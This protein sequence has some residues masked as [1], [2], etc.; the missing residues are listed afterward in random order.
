[1]V[2]LGIW[3]SELRVIHIYAHVVVKVALG[4]GRPLQSVG[5]GGHHSYGHSSYLAGWLRLF[6]SG[7]SKLS[8]VADVLDDVW[9]IIPTPS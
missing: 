2:T 5:H 8:V 6:S 1:M 4:I 9:K 3:R 7:L